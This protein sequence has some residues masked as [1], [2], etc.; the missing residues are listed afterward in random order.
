MTKRYLLLI[1]MVGGLV[2]VILF[3]I[4]VGVLKLHPFY[5]NDGR[6]RIK[7]IVYIPG[8]GLRWYISCING[9]WLYKWR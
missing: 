8:G 1:L 3:V 4:I 9:E 7:I 5:I 6:V 2:S